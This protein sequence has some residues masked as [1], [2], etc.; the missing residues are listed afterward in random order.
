MW[1]IKTSGTLNDRLDVK[2]KI[3]NKPQNP[4]YRISRIIGEHCIWWFAQ[5]R[6]WWDFKLAALST[7]C[8]ETH[9]CSIN[10]SIMA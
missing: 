6:C 10:G 7:V 2:S 1:Y 3:S 5:K 9:A 8:R 4:Y